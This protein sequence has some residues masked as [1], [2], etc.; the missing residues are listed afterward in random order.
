[1]PVF[2]TEQISTVLLQHSASWAVS[3]FQQCSAQPT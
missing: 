3:V 2:P 1:M